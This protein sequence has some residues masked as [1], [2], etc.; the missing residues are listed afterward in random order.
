[1]VGG[2]H[3]K[4]TITSMILHVMRCCGRDCDY[5]IGAQLQG[6]EVMTRLSETAPCMVIEGDEY[7]TSA[8][9]RRPKFHVYRPDIG[10]ISGIAWDHVNVFPTFE[11]YVEQFRIFANLI[12]ENG[13]FIYCAD[14]ENCC[15]V[16]EDVR[17]A[18]RKIGY[19]LPEFRVENGKYLLIH[20]GKEYPLQVFGL[21]NLLN[22]CAAYH[23]CAAVGVTDAEFFQAI[24]TFQGASNRL[25]CLYSD[26][27]KALYRDFAHSPSKLKATV[28]ALK[29]KE[30][31]RHL[32]AC[33]ELHTFSSL[34]ASFLAQYAHAMDAADEALVYF[35]PHAIALKKLPPLTE[36]M[37][38]AAFQRP[39]LK[40]FSD[41]SALYRHLKAHDWNGKNLL[42]MSSGNYDGMDV[43]KIFE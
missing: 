22:I 26:A 11:N 29:E 13:T 41:S 33:M 35:N 25:E 32:V 34:T 28:S 3:G 21:H 19:H 39:D 40:V 24:T 37:V 12:S 20:A 10:I 8:L 9:D 23:A 14:D 31:E 1:M 42:M 6:F 2:S 36:E 43:K 5:M 27:E 18:G 38:Y 15:R 17:K 16:A 4:T 30:P 7:L